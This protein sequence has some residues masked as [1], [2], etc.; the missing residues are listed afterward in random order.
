MELGARTL[1]EVEVSEGG[2]RF[3]VQ[4]DVEDLMIAP[5]AL[6]MDPQLVPTEPL[7]NKLK[8]KR[9]SEYVKGRPRKQLKKKTLEQYIN[10]LT[11][12]R[13]P[14]AQ[15]W[16]P[17]TGKEGQNDSGLGIHSII[18]EL[19]EQAGGEGSLDV[20]KRTRMKKGMGQKS[21]TLEGVQ[22]D[23]SRFSESEAEAE[24]GE[25]RRDLL[26]GGNGGT[27]HLAGPPRKKS[28]LEGV[29]DPSLSHLPRLQS[30][31]AVRVDSGV[32]SF[33][34]APS[35]SPTDL[36]TPAQLLYGSNSDAGL[37]EKYSLSPQ[38][39]AQALQY[40]RGLVLEGLTQKTLGDIARSVQAAA[41]S[42][43]PNM[44]LVSGGLSVDGSSGTGHYNPD[45]AIESSLE[46]AGGGEVD[47]A[48]MR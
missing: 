21:Q 48:E 8:L 24:S 33:S 40:I 27:S 43:L 42:E 5:L 1:S 15:M 7:D 17:R 38:H 31:L 23:S 9:K 26:V 6:R 45:E 25:A 30:Q 41:G 4:P 10:R 47:E 34:I 22:T 14:T 36:T 20:K 19:L 11:T 39:F 44:N 13:T 2:N 35:T 28:R 32:A 3:R 46:Q 18:R 37:S 16:K 29:L 12:L